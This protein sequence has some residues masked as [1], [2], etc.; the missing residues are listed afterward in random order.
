[1]VAALSTRNLGFR[2]ASV[3][4][5]VVSKE[6]KQMK[7]KSQEGERNDCR[8]LAERALTHMRVKNFGGHS[9]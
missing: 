1:M 8:L 9:R 7:G 3:E 5:C 6:V 4:M 2:V